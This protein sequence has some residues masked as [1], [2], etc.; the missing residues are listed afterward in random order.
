M[1]FNSLL[2]LNFNNY[3][4]TYTQNNK[5]HTEWLNG[6]AKVAT[7]SIMAEV[8]AIPADFA[9]D[10]VEYWKNDAQIKADIAAR[11]QSNSK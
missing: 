2:P 8:A 4:Y 7:P 1:T 6:K 11:K 5:I 9:A 3:I 10:M